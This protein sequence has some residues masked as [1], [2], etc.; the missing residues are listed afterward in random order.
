M[1]FILGHS[2]QCRLNLSQLL[3][4]DKQLINQLTTLICK[5][6][7]SPK[8]YEIRQKLLLMTNR[9]LQYELSIGTN[10]DDFGWP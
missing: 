3:D 5:R 10:I 9:N 6:S 2:V 4:P 8:G 1:L 7:I